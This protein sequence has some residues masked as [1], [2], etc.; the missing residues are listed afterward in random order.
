MKKINLKNQARSRRTRKGWGN[1]SSLGTIVLVIVFLVYGALFGLNYMVDKDKEAVQSEIKAIEKTLR[2]D[3][4]V[5]MYDFNVRLIDL[6]SRISDQ[7]LM[8]Q[9][10]NIVAISK[11]TVPEVQFL[12]FGSTDEGSYSV[13]DVEL[14]TSSYETL[15]RQIKAYKL[16][17]NSQNFFLKATQEEN[18]LLVAE[19]SF[20]IGESESLFEQGETGDNF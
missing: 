7:G 2:N 10:E 1:S 3:D 6:D 14:I 20:E 5:E 13:Y 4:F 19:F 12:R 17:E 18:G 16:M 15:I 9:S 8:P 11:N